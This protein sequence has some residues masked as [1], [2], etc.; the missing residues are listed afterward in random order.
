MFPFDNKVY[1]YKLTYADLLKVFEYAL[2]QGGQA[3]FSCEVG[4]D[5]YYSG[6][7]VQKLE[8]D[9]V[10]LYENSQWQADWA[11][12]PVTLVASE[13]LA[14]TGRPPGPAK[15]GLRVRRPPVHRPSSLFPRVKP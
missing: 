8:K 5:C 14:T 7:R 1:V 6:S 15:R 9:G 2:T 4:I 11:S 10:V 3:L 13:Y 12:R